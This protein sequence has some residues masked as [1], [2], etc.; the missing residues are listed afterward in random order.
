MFDPLDWLGHL[1][2]LR[3]FWPTQVVLS[4]NAILMLLVEDTWAVRTASGAIT[5]PRLPPWIGGGS[6]LSG[7]SGLLP[8]VTLCCYG[9]GSDI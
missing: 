6:G 7:L 8:E 5:P 4:G 3:D 1:S 2:I 9:R